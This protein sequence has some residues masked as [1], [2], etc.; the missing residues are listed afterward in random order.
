MRRS[1]AL[2]L[3]VVLVLAGCARAPKINAT[4]AAGTLEVLILGAPGTNT[5]LINAYK[6][7]NPNVTIHEVE[8]PDA[9]DFDSIVTKMKSGELKV[10][11][12][13]A[14]GNGF[15][16]DQGVVEP[17]DDLIKK[18]K[19]D[20]APYGDSITL[21]TYKGKV[22]A[23][24]VQ[25]SPM[26]V[27]YN[28][29]LF[30]QVGA[31]LPQPN[32]TWDDF[33]KA[34]ALLKPAMAG[35]TMSDGT[36]ITPW[37][38]FDLVLTSGKGP[39]DP[40]LTAMQTTLTR[41][42]QLMVVDK[43]VSDSTG[44]QGESDYFMAFNKG[45]IGMLLSYWENSFSHETPQMKWG[46]APVPGSP[47]GRVPAQANMAMVAAKATNKEQAFNFV[48]FVAGSGGAQAIAAMP[49]APIPG[50]INSNVEHIWL[51]NS[52][53]PGESQSLLK[54]QYVPQ[55]DYPQ[56]LA[57]PLMKEVSNTLFGTKSPADAIRDYKQVQQPLL[58]KK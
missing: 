34:A 2:L 18:Q 56:D 41:L 44:G 26:V 15:L 8:L 46:I 12:F 9:D 58:P 30:A 1:I 13:I 3:L 37:S 31:P 28:A 47:N 48:K 22:W 11:A 32:W 57:L 54:Q 38:A 17:L 45:K 53:L 40:D 25:V 35:K 14:P 6:A 51:A 39:A 55:L 10:D 50:Y 43:T 29:D 16:F 24:P 5:T 23:L 42:H 19:V 4:G 20:L 52:G 27:V 21:G 7:A 33:A 36:T 49:G